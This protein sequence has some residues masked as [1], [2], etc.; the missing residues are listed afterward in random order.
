MGSSSSRRLL[1]PGRTIRMIRSLYST[2]SSSIPTIRRIRSSRSL[3]TTS[4]STLSI[5]TATNTISSMGSG[6]SI[7]VAGGG[8]RYDRSYS[9]AGS[10]SNASRFNSGVG[11]AG[12]STSGSECPFRTPLQAFSAAA[13]TAVNR[14]F[15][16]RLRHAT[17][18]VPPGASAIRPGNGTSRAGIPA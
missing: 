9:P 13:T 15:G 2:S 5:T 11:F 7:F 17:A 3:G 4:T 1:P 16:L 12:A 14:L 6:H 18:I 8:S 10:L